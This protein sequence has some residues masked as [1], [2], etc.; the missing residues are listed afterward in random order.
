M[1]FNLEI[2]AFRRV[3]GEAVDAYL[4]DVFGYSNKDVSFEDAHF[5]KYEWPSCCYSGW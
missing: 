2:A 5:C 4:P 3:D 1:S